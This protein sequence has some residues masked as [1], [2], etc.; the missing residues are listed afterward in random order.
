MVK[1]SLT[2]EEGIR[3]HTI[4]FSFNTNLNFINGN[5]AEK[6]EKQSGCILNKRL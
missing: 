1:Y 5:H 2:E 4:N 6:K 3:A